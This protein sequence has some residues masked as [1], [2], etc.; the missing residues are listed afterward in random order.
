MF[1]RSAGGRTLRVHPVD[2]A[3]TP[4]KRASETHTNILG[5][6]LGHRCP[7]VFDMVNVVPPWGLLSL[8]FCVWHVSLA[9][10]GQRLSC[11]AALY[12][13]MAKHVMMLGFACFRG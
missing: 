5:K 6:L 12:K 9:G 2:P 1:D 13:L 4:G 8:A 7:Q 11:F 3:K 10:G